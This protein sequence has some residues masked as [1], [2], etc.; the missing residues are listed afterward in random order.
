MNRVIVH[1]EQAL[2]LQGGV[3]G[4]REQ[5]KCQCLFSV[6]KQR[7]ISEL[8]KGAQTSCIEINTTNSEDESRPCKRL[9]S[10][11]S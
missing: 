4:L 6:Y 11:L 7:L 2:L 1:R 9:E 3:V 10:A 5:R 8:K